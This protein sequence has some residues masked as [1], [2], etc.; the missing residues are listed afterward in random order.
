MSE[1]P[2]LIRTPEQANAPLTRIRPLDD[3]A[4]LERA[5]EGLRRLPCPS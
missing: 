4:L 2:L 5:L 1:Q 3:P